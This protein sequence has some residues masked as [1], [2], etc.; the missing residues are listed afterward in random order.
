MS[1]KKSRGLTGNG[2]S[3]VEELCDWKQKVVAYSGGDL[4]EG[5]EGGVGLSISL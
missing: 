1:L 2:P 3:D 4:L 5:V